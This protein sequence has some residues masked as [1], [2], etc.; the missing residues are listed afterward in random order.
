MMNKASRLLSVLLLPAALTACGGGGTS[1]T[2]A[3]DK[4]AQPP[5][6]PEPVELTF[7]YT[8]TGYP[9]ADFMRD[10]G[11][12]IKHR[13]PHI[14]IKFMQSTK[15][16]TLAE[17]IAARADVDVIFT[18]I[19]ALSGVLDSGIAQDLTDTVQTDKFDLNRLEPQSVDMVRKMSGGKLTALPIKSGAMVLFYNKDLFDKF[20]VAYPK[21][22]MTWDDVYE[23]A[24]K[25]TRVEG[26]QQYR[27]FV[28]STPHLAMTNPYSLDFI[29]PLTKKATFD[30]G[31][32]NPF[33]ET[34][35][36]L[37]QLPGYEA[38]AK[39]LSGGTQ[40]D[41]FYKD[42]TAAM[43]VTFSSNYPRANEGMNWDVVRYPSMKDRPGVGAQPY[44]A[45]FVLSAT[46]KH[47][48]DAFRAIAH[49]T[50]DEVQM[51]QARIGNLPVVNNTSVRAVF[52]QDIPDLKGKNVLSMVE[53][54]YAPPRMY[55]KYDGHAQSLITTAFTEIITGTKDTNTALRHAAANLNAKIAEIDGK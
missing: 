8:S 31:R 39:V 1:T 49:L 3:A 10:Y 38:D 48:E 54:N 36:R 25:L 50:S 32:W 13:Y 20:G 17:L 51:Q 7:L 41:L 5:K 29:D 52:G 44:P 27:G 53:T 35:S 24:K 4:Q 22:G 9:D 55:T 14:S 40:S 37:Y 46:S 18:S 34:I 12:P 11:D 30:N 19:G 21:D 28:A 43:Y 42:R 23:T 33:V 45:Y 2:G 26:G 47:K 6:P 16:N 15:G